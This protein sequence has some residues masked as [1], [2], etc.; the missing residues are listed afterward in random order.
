M[1]SRHNEIFMQ[2]ALKLE[3]SIQIK[4]PYFPFPKYWLTLKK[5]FSESNIFKSYLSNPLRLQKYKICIKLQ[6]E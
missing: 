2:N 1:K 6:A 4:C 5:C 3:I